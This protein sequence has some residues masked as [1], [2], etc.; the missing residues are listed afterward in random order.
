[1]AAVILIDS[2]ILIDVLGKAQAWRDWSR[3]KL[4]TLMLDD[5]LAVNQV[6]FAEVAPR[7]GSLERFHARLADFQIAFE[8]FADDAAFE[9]GRAFLAYRLQRREAKQV[10]PDFFIGGHALVAGATILTRDPRFYRSYFPSVPL[11]TPD[12]A[13]K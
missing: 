7:T 4:A 10:L 5:D 9:A 13:E 6:V 2:N 11:I 12:K 8:P 3:A 1:L